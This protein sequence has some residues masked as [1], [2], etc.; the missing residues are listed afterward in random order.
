MLGPLE[1]FLRVWPIH[2]LHQNHTGCLFMK[3]N[4]PG[5][6]LPNLTSQPSIRMD[7]SWPG[8]LPFNKFPR[9]S[10]SSENPENHCQMIHTS[11]SHLLDSKVNVANFFVLF[12][13][14]HQIP[15]L[16]NLNLN[17]IKESPTSF[18]K[19]DNLASFSKSTQFPMWFLANVLIY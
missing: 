18:W 7:G 5:A 6:C 12:L 13:V 1:K 15:T 8:N 2:S 14:L 16:T 19:R 9:W 10:L 11:L 17:I 3:I 4:I